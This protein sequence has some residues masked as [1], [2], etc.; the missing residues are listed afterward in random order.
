MTAASLKVSVVGPVATL[1]LTRAEAHN[2]LD[3]ELVGNLVHAVQKLGVA[4]LVR[5][6][7]LAAEGPSFC[8]GS[9]LTAMRRAADLDV[10]EGSREAM[11]VAILLDALARCP[12]PVVAAV[13]GPALG[14]GVGLLAACDV[15]L[16]AETATFALSEIRLGL[17]PAV[18]VPALVAAIGERACRRYLLSGERFDAREAHRLGLVHAVV[19][20]D[21]LDGARGLMVEQLLKGAPGAQASVKDLLRVASET[22]AGPDLMRYT[23]Q[24]Q[25]EIAAGSEA[26]DGLAAFADK[27]KPG[28][29][30]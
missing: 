23:A 28:W 9:D 15:V 29:V 7:V 27:R 21:R 26:R 4:E 25:A 3:D 8:A 11:Q 24:R 19:A 18:I 5:V 6:V 12:K 16:A 2:A 1:T 20:A 10:A 14:I 22:A 13:Q 30:G 17:V